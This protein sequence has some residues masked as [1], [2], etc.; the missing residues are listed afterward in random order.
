MQLSSKYAHFLTEEVIQNNPKLNAVWLEGSSA[1]KKGISYQ[2]CPMPIDS[3][4][5]YCW[6]QGWDMEF[7]GGA[8]S[9]ADFSH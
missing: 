1:Y 2:R 9:I 3:K 8:S 4:E 5:E 7:F 6:K